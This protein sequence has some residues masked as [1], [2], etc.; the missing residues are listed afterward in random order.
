MNIR[1]TPSSTGGEIRAVA[2]KSVAHRMLICAAFAK[3]ETRILCRET[4]EDIEATVACLVALGARIE[5]EGQYLRV[6]PV[7]LLRKNAL[8]NCRESGSTLRFLIPVC[9]LMGA[10]ASFLMSGRLPERPLS[11]LREELERCG[12]SF[13]EA[14]SNPLSVT[15]RVE[16]CEFSIR[17]DVSSQFITGL[18]LG[19]AVSGRVGKINIIGELQSAPYVEIT[20]DVLKCFGVSVITTG[21]SYVIDAT[22]GLVAEGELFAAGDWSGAAFPLC[23]GAIGREAV[24]VTGLDPNS[25]QGD[26]YIVDI[27]ESMGARVERRGDSVTVYPSTLHGVRIDARQI[28][29]LVPVATVLCALAEGE[30]HIYN[31]ER[32]RIKE[33]DRLS[34]VAQTLNALGAQVSELPDGLKIVGVPTLTGGRVSSFGDHRIVMSAAI[35]SVR[36]AEDVI[37]LGAEAVGKSYPSFFEDMQA[38]GASLFEE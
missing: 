28:P 32:L 22:G 38:L 5:R 18:M 12:V 33:S 34:A 26:K 15:G 9:A 14:G 4:N 16:E 19:L 29:D 35:A 10:D 8:L 2:S 20:S 7:E 13:S 17:G 6:C 27:L 31:A 30:S 23:L 3:N 37:V 21:D 1:L 24:T 36:C 11:P 25:R